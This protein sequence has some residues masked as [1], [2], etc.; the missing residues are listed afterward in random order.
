MQADSVLLEPYYDFE[1]KLDR[2][3]IGRAMTDLERMGAAFTIN[4]TGDEVS[5]TG[6]GPVSCLGN[7]QAEVNAYT[8]GTGS[9]SLRMSGYSLATIRMK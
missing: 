6:N 1:L 7:Y 5:I 4:D 8:K 2:Q 3:Y 9:I